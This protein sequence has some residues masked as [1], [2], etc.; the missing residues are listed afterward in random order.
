MAADDKSNADN[1]IVE[2]FQFTS[3]A[4]TQKAT[5]DASKIRLLQSRVKSSK[6]TDIKAV[7]EKS[8]ENKIFKTPIGWCYLIGLRIRLI[9]SGYSE[10]DIIP[11]PVGVSFSRHSA[12]ESLSVKQ[13]IKP[14]KKGKKVD[15]TKIL[16]IICNIVLVILVI[17]LFVIAATAENDNIINYKS[18]VTNRYASWEQDLKEREKKVRIAEKRLG[19]TDTSSYYED[20]ENIDDNQED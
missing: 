12:I 17:L 14:E 16:S 2:G 5:M 15:F 19:I 7:Y 10:E 1:F 3:E 9:E 6:P 18:N 4:D 13:R 8:I 11:I 20:T